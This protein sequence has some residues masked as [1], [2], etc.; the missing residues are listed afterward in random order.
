MLTALH[1]LAVAQAVAPNEADCQPPSAGEVIV[2]GSRRGESP[3]R[4][5]KV[6][7]TYDH[8]DRKI[9]AEAELAPGVSARAHVESARLPDGAQSNRAMVTIKLHF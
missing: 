7:D 5:P 2:C 4:L 1:L 8:P 3:Y 9:R 6:P